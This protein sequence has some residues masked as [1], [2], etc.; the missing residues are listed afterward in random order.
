[1]VTIEVS[2][3]CHYRAQNSC[4]EVQDF[5]GITVRFRLELY[6]LCNREIQ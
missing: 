1:M 5:E 3:A 2:W 4:A 6:E